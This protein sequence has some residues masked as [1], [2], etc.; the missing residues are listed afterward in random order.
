MK[1]ALQAEPK[2][3]LEQVGKSLRF[4]TLLCNWADRHQN[5]LDRRIYRTIYEARNA[6]MTLRVHLFYKV[7][8]LDHI[9]ASTEGRPYEYQNDVFFG[10]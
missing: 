8:D 6:V 7:I 5:Q 1:P 2:H 10:S 4:H 3:E 9:R